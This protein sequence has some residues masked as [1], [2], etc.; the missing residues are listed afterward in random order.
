MIEELFVDLELKEDFNSRWYELNKYYNYFFAKPI[1]IACQ[2]S[3]QSAQGGHDGII[4]LYATNDIKNSNSSIK[5]K[6]ININSIAGTKLLIINPIY[7]YIKIC[8]KANNTTNVAF[9]AILSIINSNYL[10]NNTLEW[11]NIIGDIE[12]QT[13][14]EDILNN[15]AD[16]YFNVKAVE[17]LPA[18][19][20][21]SILGALCNQGEKSIGVCDKTWLMGEIANIANI[22][23]IAIETMT[24]INAGALLTSADD[25]KAKN[26]LLDD[27]INGRALESCS[28]AGFI[29]IKIL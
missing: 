7:H 6:A 4:E 8:Y 26:A 17:A 28:T 24:A 16:K 21:V 12:N 15:K 27:N 13:D 9:N 18:F 22:G 1:I 11:G 5:I 14:L 19:R 10:I 3:W 2:L 23:N 20:F 29:K 25:G